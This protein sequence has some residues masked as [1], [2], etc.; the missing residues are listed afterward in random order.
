MKKKNFKFIM[1]L[2]LLFILIMPF[3]NILALD[4]LKLKV[5]KTDLK[6][7]DEIN[8]N[9]I[10][11][12]DLNTYAMLAT[13]KYDENVFSKIDD[14]N[15]SVDDTKSIAYNADTNKF[16]IVNKT[17]QIFGSLFNVR[18]K[19]KED[20]KVGDTNIGLTNISSSDGNGTISFAPATVKVS[21]TKDA[22]ENDVVSKIEENE[23]KADEENIQKVF[24]SSPVILGLAFISIILVVGAIIILIKHDSNK[25]IVYCLISIAVIFLIISVTLFIFNTNKKDV[26]NDGVKDYNDAEEIIKY[27]IDIKGTKKDD[28]SLDTD[29]LTNYND[30]NT[31]N[32]GATSLQNPS[33]TNQEP[34]NFLNNP[35]ASN[36]PNN[37]SSSSNT[38]NNNSGNN[39]NSN[40]KPDSNHDTNNDGKVDIE[41]VG[42][43]VDDV[44]KK[45]KVTLTIID[46]EKYINKG[47][48]TL[49]FKADITPKGLKISKIKINDEYYD[50]VLNN[51][52]YTVNIAK[53][54]KAGIYNFKIS[55][56]ILNNNN[57]VKTKLEITKEVLKEAP[58]INKFDLNDEAKSISFDLVDE[59]EAFIDGV[60]NIYDENDDLIKSESVKDFNVINDLALLNDKIYYVEIIGNYDLDSNKND[61][62][63]HF[64]ENVMFDHEFMLGGDYNFNLN[65]IA[66]TDA[67]LPNEKPVI[68]F[69][70]TNTRNAL[71]ANATLTNDG[72]TTKNY[73]IS[74][75][76]N[77]SYEI[78]LNDADMTIGEHTV[79]LDNVN[80]DS[81]KTFEKEKDYENKVLT[82]TVLKPAPTVLNLTANYDSENKNVLVNFQLK[83]DESALSKLKVV[84]VDST[85]K[86]ASSRIITDYNTNENIDVTLSCA[87]NTD[88]FYTVMVLGDYQL[89]DKYIYTNKA[90]GKTTILTHSDDIYITD[91]YVTNN[92]LYPT[93][94]QTNYQLTFKVYVA[95]S[96]VNSRSY[97]TV[98]GITI[99]G[100]NYSATPVN[101]QL[102]TSTVYLNVPVEAG[103]MEIKANRVQLARN[104]YFHILNDYFSVVDKT[105]QVEVLKDKPQIE[106]L[107]I[108]DDY[109]NE[110]TTFNFDVNLD[111]KASEKEEEFYDGAIELNNQKLPIKRGSNSVTF[112]NVERDQTF[113][114]MF[115]GSYDLDSDELNDITDEKNEIKDDLLYK[116]K[117][118]LY[119]N[120]AYE[121]IKIINGKTISN[122]NNEYFEKNEKVKLNFDITGILEQLDSA[123]VKV[124]IDNQEYNI[125]KITDGYELI[126]DGYTS[127]GKKDITITEVV[128][129]NGRRLQLKNPYTFNL[130]VLKDAIKITNYKYEEEN[131]KIN[132]YL[133]FKDSD[134]SLVNDLKVKI[135]DELGN[136]LYNDKY[137]EQISFNKNGN[138]LRYYINVIG[139]YDRDIDKLNAYNSYQ[140]AVLLEDII[141]LEKNVIELKN[142][143]DINVYKNSNDAISL[144]DD[145]N[146]V[147]LKNNY[148]DYFVE[149]IMDDMPSVR[150]LIKNVIDDD[151]NLV[152][153]LDYQYVSSD[154]S[155][156]N[157]ELKIDMGAIINNICKNNW[158]PKDAML[159]LIADLEAGL[160]VTL[161]HNY[162]FSSVNTEFESYVTKEYK[163]V[164]NGN[165]FT[166]KNLSKP[167]FNTINEGEVKNL[168]LENINL[169]PNGHGALANRIVKTKVTNVFVNKVVNKATGTLGE[170]GGLVGYASN[171]TILASRASNVQLNLEY[172]VQQN[173]TFIGHVDKNT[174]IDNCYA[175]GTINSGWNYT[176]GFVGNCQSSTLTNNYVKVTLNGSANNFADSFSDNKSEYKNNICLATNG[177]TSFVGAYKNIANNYLY[178][179]KPLEKELEGVTIIS[180]ENIND[181]LFKEKA[182]F[183]SDYWK[184]KNVSYNNLPILNAEYTSILNSK[185]AVEENEMLYKNL[186]KLMPFYN[187]D[188][189]IESS[190]N[191]KDQLFSKQEIK[192]LVPIDASGNIVTYLTTKNPKK[193]NKLKIVFNNGEKREYNVIYDKTYDM[194]ASYRIIDLGCEYNYNHYVINEDSQVVNNLTNY[195]KGLNYPNNLDILTSNDDSRI[196]RD[197]YNETTK[198]NL[199]EFIL[200]YLANTNYTNINNEKAINNYIEKEIKKDNKLEK[201]LYVYNYLTRFYDLD[202]DG[203]KVYDFIL[204]DM[205]G[206][207]NEI[208]ESLTFDKVI[209]LFMGDSSGNN[210]NTGGTNTTYVNVLSKYTSFATVP[211]FISYLVNNFSNYDMDDWVQKQFKGILEEIKIDGHEDVKYTLWD[212][213]NDTKVS[214][215]LNQFLPILTLNENAA[216]IISMPS[217]YIIGAQRTYI[218]DPTNPDDIKFLKEKMAT[219]VDRMKNYFETAYAILQDKDLFNNTLIYHVDKRY[220]KDINGASVFNTVYTTTEDFHKNF[221]E[222]TGLWAAA[223]GFN[224]AAWGPRLEWQVAGV[225]DS[226]LKTDG[227]NDT[228]HVTFR[229]WSHESAHLIDGAIFLKNNKR[230]FDAGGEDYADCFL[231]QAFNQN[232]IVM[233]LSMNFNKDYHV[234]SNL[235]PQRINSPEKV[236]DFYRKLFE[237]VYVMDYI[238]AKAFLQLSSEEQKALAVQVSYP[239]ENLQF[240]TDNGKSDGKLIGD[241]YSMDPY[242]KYRA[243][244]VS[245][246]THLSEYEGT[247]K[248][249]TIDE[250]IDNRIMLYPGIN[251]YS[252]RGRDSYGGEGIQQVHWYQPNNPDGRADSYALKW[253]SYEMLGYKGYDEGFVEFAS[254]INSKKEKIYKNLL[255]PSEGLSDVDYKTDNMAIRK[256]TNNEYQNITEYKKARFKEVEENINRLDKEINVKEYVNKFYIALQKDAKES[257]VNY[258]NSNEIRQ[259]IFYTL[260]NKTNDFESEIYKS[261]E[262]QDVSDLTINKQ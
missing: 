200:K 48:I 116:V 91:M 251:K 138:T 38:N 252:S 57:S 186:L 12:D 94:G 146:V 40:Q 111:A 237:T 218:K 168:R 211:K 50:V 195:L 242:A 156:E 97:T 180:E 167:L 59:D 39:N 152:L 140:D 84:L 222:V 71:I 119:D 229:T 24:T 175:T 228:S 51:D 170:N 25:K 1:A 8:V 126:L 132:I 54:N 172:L 113:D 215:I 208:N 145:I 124:V 36:L 198:N 4:G 21:V 174:T 220:T 144:I 120:T 123:I 187:S 28:S 160:D 199:Q 103:V 27:L 22:T 137:Q 159:K 185:D 260:K 169:N 161:L 11:P 191:I 238:E 74:K 230:R 151:N 62:N 217:E 262:Q 189:I 104:N 246:F 95:D 67:I 139:D 7:G 85:G 86:I 249:N 248:F 73:N 261:E 148:R 99:N 192:H 141:S 105:M 65:N 147:D 115:K 26:N 10:A 204:F 163:G 239:N 110:K 37:N 69:N 121:N 233:N 122:S 44:N 166:I 33:S 82:Y 49:K 240:A 245:K 13:L 30:N 255:S 154:I 98:S 23:I 179:N 76:L 136:I 150:A 128:F 197:F 112:E 232:D 114:L 216:Y 205:S 79:T 3:K 42:D 212:H 6:V 258:S 133:N 83:D 247:F 171:S 196:Y 234:A 231:M 41:D 88:G 219:Y 203:M 101:R 157:D 32:S 202:I 43:I 165:G 210:F 15:F 241:T 68:S 181:D 227:T 70:S 213:F 78:I 190:I 14:S 90:I 17:G 225:M 61:N 72:V 29:T 143:A 209:D 63:N 244:M 226:V 164:L 254:N 176:A 2:F 259:E 75:I 236:Q 52:I 9:V 96:I 155:L 47:E 80:L 117:Y 77:D 60:I 134:N 100:L 129:D 81:L 178:V 87:N 125:N 135:T 214:E 34:D 89:T 206:F 183:S 19:V 256:I 93:K 92:N 149:I 250:L 109:E 66:I 223:E 16:G 18:L 257:N 194:V 253:F 221:V 235:T 107:V 130:E 131:D 56:V 207:K 153:V 162:D 53:V 46:D 5:D 55:E 201:A 45:S 224:A 31:N 177:N 243:R 35:P 118:G 142:V 158:H 106:N 127:S 184:I 188:K 102:F 64:N 108:N 20:A 58:Y 182:Q 173:G 193:I